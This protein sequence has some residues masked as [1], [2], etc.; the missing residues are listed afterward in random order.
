M[1]KEISRNCQNANERRGREA[2]LSREL[3]VP[4]P[5]F[6]VAECLGRSKV[7]S[8]HRK[9]PYQLVRTSAA[10]GRASYCCPPRPGLWPVLRFL[11]GPPSCR[12]SCQAP[13][14]LS[15]PRVTSCLDSSPSPAIRSHHL[16]LLAQ[17][18]ACV[19]PLPA[20][21]STCSVPGP[22]FAA[23]S[24]GEASLPSLSYPLPTVPPC[25][26]S[27]DSPVFYVLSGSSVPGGPVFH[28]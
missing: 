5:D 2:T 25:F 20:P 12:S 13:S 7:R 17:G 4:G 11:P 24:L 21:M 26:F 19:P 14:R 18:W 1:R 10:G 22:R 23:R 6:F 3:W 27:G 15:L 8:G 16:F 9:K 28:Y